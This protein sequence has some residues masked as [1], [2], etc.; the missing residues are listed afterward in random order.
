MHAMRRYFGIPSIIKVRM[1]NK[2]KYGIDLLRIL[3]PF[4]VIIKRCVKHIKIDV[5]YLLLKAFMIQFY[6][7]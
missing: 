1:I 6:H 3:N 2:K 7:L 4:M 5:D